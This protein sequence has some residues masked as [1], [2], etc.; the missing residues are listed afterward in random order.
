MKQYTQGPLS[1]NVNSYHAVTLA[2]DCGLP[3]ASIYASFNDQANAARLVACWNA[4]EGMADPAAELDTLRA[5]RDALRDALA[6]LAEAAQY[7]ETRTRGTQYDS[8]RLRMALA[9][10]E[11]AK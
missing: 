1:V 10:L 11:G 7:T 3:V 9:A 4:C 6:E 5:Q 2:D 8:A